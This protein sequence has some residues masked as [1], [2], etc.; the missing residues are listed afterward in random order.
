MGILM[1]AQARI[2]GL[3]DVRV[4]V[5]DLLLELLAEKDGLPA[6]IFRRRAIDIEEI[7]SAASTTRDQ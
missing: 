4:E 7:R 3:G 1:R 2:R 6:R 5:D